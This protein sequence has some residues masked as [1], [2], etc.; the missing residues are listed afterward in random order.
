[1]KRI[2]ISILL[3]V[4]TYS[5][6]NAQIAGAKIMGKNLNN[7]KLGYGLFTYYDIPVNDIGNKSVRIE[8]AD[9][10]Y[11]PTKNSDTGLFLP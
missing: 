7:Y 11:F 6:G 10:A 5:S 9:F 3:V 4:I 8:L 1:M 2:F